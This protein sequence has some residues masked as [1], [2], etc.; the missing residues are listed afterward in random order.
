MDVIRARSLRTQTS[1]SH[2]QLYMF[3]YTPSKHISKCSTIPV[4]LFSEHSLGTVFGSPIFADCS[5]KQLICL[6]GQQRCLC[7][8]CDGCHMW[9]VTWMGL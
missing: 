9:C 8:L 2:I 5:A 3:N 6:T 7:M 1:I 4:Y